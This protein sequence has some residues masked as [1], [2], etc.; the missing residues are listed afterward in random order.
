MAVLLCGVILF[1]TAL[2]IHVVI[3]RVRKPSSPLKTLL[4]ILL[5]VIFAGLSALYFTADSLAASGF[6]TLD[7][8]AAYLHTLLFCVSL[9]LAYVVSYTLLEWDSPTLTIVMTIARA[10]RSGAPEAE[11]AQLVDRLPFIGSRIQCLIRDNVITEKDG[12]YVISPG[13]HL[14]YRFVLSYRRLLKADKRAG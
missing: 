4:L 11:L 9:S 8:L 3:W 2:V 7:T 5:A 1:F 13:H 6:A 10:G 14:F 12:R